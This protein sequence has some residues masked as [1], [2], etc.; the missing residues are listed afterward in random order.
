MAKEM[1]FEKEFLKNALMKY[2]QMEK[3]YFDVKSNI[4]DEKN[5]F[6]LYFCREK[7]N[8]IQDF[9][10]NRANNAATLYPLAAACAFNTGAKF[11]SSANGF[12][13]T[14]NNTINNTTYE[15]KN[16]FFGK[17]EK[18]CIAWMYLLRE[19]DNDSY[20]TKSLAEFSKCVDIF[21]LQFFADLFIPQNYEFATED[22]KKDQSTKQDD[23][24]EDV[25]D[26]SSNNLSIAFDTSNSVQLNILFRILDLFDRFHIHRD[27]H[28]SRDLV[29]GKCES[30]DNPFYNSLKNHIDDS[31]RTI[32]HI[33]VDVVKP[34]DEEKQKIRKKLNEKCGDNIWGKIADLNGVTLDSL[35][36]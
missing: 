21:N 28:K 13:F 36:K 25:T 7:E 26:Q 15:Y 32:I 10:S 2:P 18:L 9:Y 5:F 35:L 1:E 16:S 22:P 23:E 29:I 27:I 33:Y 14:I 24:E 19:D 11:S 30:S 8:A 17:S 20:P 3:R 34:N 4:E 12:S 6:K 31:F